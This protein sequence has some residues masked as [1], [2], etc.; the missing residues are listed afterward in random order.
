MCI[1]KIASQINLELCIVKRSIQIEL[2]CHVQTLK[3]VVP[4]WGRIRMIRI[5]NKNAE[6]NIFLPHNYKFTRLQG[7]FYF[8]LQACS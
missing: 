4:H 1:V 2:K 7:I 8:F 5:M 6:N 3:K